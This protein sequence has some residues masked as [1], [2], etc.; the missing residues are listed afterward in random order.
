MKMDFTAIQLLLSFQLSING[1]IS[2]S[3]ND[4]AEKWLNFVISPVPSGLIFDF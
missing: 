2:D 4:E 1:W 3:W